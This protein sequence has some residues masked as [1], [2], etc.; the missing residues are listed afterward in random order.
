MTD[1]AER[2]D[3]ETDVY[4]PAE[5][6]RLLLTQA[7]DDIEAGH[8]VLEVGTGSGFVAVR[9][10]ADTDAQVVASD[11]NPHACRQARDGA[12]EAGVD[13]EVIRADLTKPFAAG[14]FDRVVFNPPYL[15]ADS[16]AAQDDW[17]EVA[18]SGGET[19]RAVVEP[20]LDD[21]ARVLAPG[22]R[23]LLLISTLTG[24]GEVARY[25]DAQGLFA[26]TLAEETHPYERLVVLALDE[27]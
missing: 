5:D 15:P 1:L 8:R 27:E 16:D 6:T 18:L 17:M 14:S 13:I 10:A 25:A 11:L 21:V 23:A 26:R 2:R 7:L 20:F 3:I 9:L 12:Q 4:Q 22:G 24:V 19:G